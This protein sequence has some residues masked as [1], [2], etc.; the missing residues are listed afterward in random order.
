METLT[1]RHDAVIANLENPLISYW[2]TRELEA[3]L[4]DIHRHIHIQFNIEMN[5]RIQRD[6]EENLREPDVTPNDIELL[7]TSLQRFKNELFMWKEL[8]ADIE[9]L[10]VCRCP[11]NKCHY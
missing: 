9:N 10:Y 3:E 7:E 1:Q 5:E 6:I 11:L 4:Q 8:L 2:M